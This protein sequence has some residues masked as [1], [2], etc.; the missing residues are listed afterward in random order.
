M[1]F[2]A[3]KENP[4][5]QE[6]REYPVDFGHPWQEKFNISIQIPDGYVVETLPKAMNIT[7]GE[8]VGLFKYSITNTGNIVQVSITKD[9]NSAIVLPHF[10]DVLKD[11]FQQMVDKQNEKIV[12]KKV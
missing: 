9:M 7:T 1:V 3:L 11:F 4:F 12:L 6:V 2:L 10:Y 5:K 8:N